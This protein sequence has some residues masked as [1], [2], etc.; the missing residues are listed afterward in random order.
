[1][2]LVRKK[3]KWKYGPFE[4][5]KKILNEWREIGK[6]GNIQE[7][8]WNNIYNKK[9]KKVKD[10][11]TRLISGKLPKNLDKIIEEEKRKFFDSNLVFYLRE[12]YLQK[13]NNLA[14]LIK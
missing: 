7:K 1:V 10:E 8:K 11:F 4:I 14:P 12:L 6:R 5:P 9:G 13:I 3:L 2:Q